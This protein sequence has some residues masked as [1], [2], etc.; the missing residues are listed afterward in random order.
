M[1]TTAGDPHS[2]RRFPFGK[3]ILGVL[4]G[5]ALAFAFGAGALLAYQGQYADRVYPGVTVDGVDVSGLTRAAATARLQDQLAGYSKGTAVIAIDGEEVRIPYAALGRRADVDALVE[6]AWAVGRG[7]GDPL[8]RATQA[9][10]S[11]VDGTGISPVVMVDPEAVDRE[12]TAL[13]LRIN[14]APVSGSATATAAGFAARP[15]VPGKVLPRAEIVGALLRQ[16]PDPA[17][18]ETLELAYQTAP[19]APYIDDAAV[20]DAIASAN[21]MATDVVLATGAETWTI[22]GATVRSWIQFKTTT[23]GLRPVVASK[24]PKKALVAL[25]KKIDRP[26]RDA[27]F[28]VQGGSSALRVVPGANGRALD[29]AATAPLVAR[30]IAERVDATVAPKPVAVAITVVKP[31]LSTQEARKVAPRMRKVSSWTT[32][33]EVS[34]RNGFSNN[35]SI[36]ARDLDGTVVAPGAVFDFW[37][38]IG[39]VTAARGYRSGGAIINGRSQPTGAFAGGICSTSTTLFNAV[40]RAG[41]QTLAKHNHAYYISRYPTGLDATVAIVNGSVTTMSWR[42]DSKYPVMIRSSARPGV[43]SF[44]LWAVA[45]NSRPAVGGGSRIPGSTNL[46]YRVAN[47]RTVSFATSAKRNYDRAGSSVKK[48]TA[49]PPGRVEVVECCAVDGFDITVSRTVRE[50]GTVIH[51]DTWVSHYKTV[52]ALT[53]IGAKR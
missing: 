17:A 12:L 5:F 52:D 50:G 39:P 25:A 40:V 41:Y 16:L 2:S 29:V 23:D 28:R 33:Y 27:T 32:Y 11:A 34:E 19:V 9:V 4:A 6:L 49:L 18:P 13:A 24:A 51:R 47:G 48:T 21:R 46:T 38:S 42:N 26:P 36:P 7:G 44:S 22:K 3:L 31:K 45:V 20:A 53:L 30:A 15:A 10:R 37:Q 1:T 35:I 43:V 14:R 8:G